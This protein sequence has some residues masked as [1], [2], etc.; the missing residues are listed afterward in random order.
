MIAAIVLVHSGLEQMMFYDGRGTHHG[1]NP[2]RPS[3]RAVYVLQATKAGVEA[4]ER[5]YTI[6]TMLVTN[7]RQT[8]QL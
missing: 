5:G 4:W 7:K 2:S 6:P 3:P 1:R 8:G